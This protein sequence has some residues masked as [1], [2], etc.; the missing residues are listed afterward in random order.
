MQ[1]E[2]WEAPPGSETHKWLDAGD[3]LGEQYCELKLCTTRKPR[4]KRCLGILDSLR[5]IEVRIR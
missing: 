5:E 3:T 4:V 2:F 1:T